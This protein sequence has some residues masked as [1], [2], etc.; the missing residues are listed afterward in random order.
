MESFTSS[1]HEEER[2]S[3]MVLPLKKGKEEFALISLCG[4][5]GREGKKGKGGEGAFSLNG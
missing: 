1:S 3:V 4:K 2:N 5:T